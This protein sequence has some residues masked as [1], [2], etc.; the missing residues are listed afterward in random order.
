MIT[1]T[2][3]RRPQSEM[4]KAMTERSLRFVDFDFRSRAERRQDARGNT[5]PGVVRSGHIG[6][7]KYM[8]HIGAKERGRYA[9]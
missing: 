9:A 8:P 7:S 3:R 6:P 1:K 5:A 2:K 4:S